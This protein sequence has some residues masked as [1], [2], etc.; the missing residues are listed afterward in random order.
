MKYTKLILG[1]FLVSVMLSA[2]LGFSQEVTNPDEVMSVTLLSPNSNAARNQ[3]ANLMQNELPKA[4]IGVAE[5]TNAGWDVVGPRTFAYPVSDTNVG[6][7]TYAD[8]GYDMVFIGLSGSLAYDPTGSYSTETLAPA[9]LNFAYYENTDLDELIVEYRTDLNATSRSETAKDIQA[10]LYED[11]PYI[12]IVN[13]A[14]LWASDSDMALTETELLFLGT[15]N[16]GDQWKGIS[17]PTDKDLVYAHSYE[18]TEFVPF[19]QQSYIAAAYMNTI[20]TGLY[21]RDDSDV[22][23]DY[24]PVLANSAPVWNTDYTVA[25]VSLNPAAKFSN[26]NSVTANDVVNTYRMHLTPAV[27]STLYGDIAPFMDK[28][29]GNESIVALDN[30]T[31]QFH[32]EDPYF[33]AQ[34]VMSIGVMDASVIGDYSSVSLNSTDFNA[35]AT[36]YG[37]GAGPFQYSDIDSANGNVKVTKVANYWN[38][39]VASDSVSFVKKTKTAVLSELASG[40]VHIADAQ[41]GLEKGEVEDLAGVSFAIVADFGTQFLTVN[42]K[43]PV[44]GTGVETPV[45]QADPTKAAEA[46]RNVR[47]AISHL[48][49][50]QTIIDDLLQGKGTAGTSLWPDVAAGYDSSLAVYEYSVDKAMEYLELAGYEIT[51]STDTTTSSQAANATS[52]AAETTSEA[53]FVP[54]EG[55]IPMAF[56][57]FFSSLMLI[58]RRN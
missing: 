23:Y 20:F 28:S 43:H 41:F 54:F 48:I 38:G 40:D 25:N 18:L 27:A 15:L 34:G 13:T 37:V 55:F 1:A 2:P 22:N 56:M 57:A 24:M 45:G 33:L 8:G 5:H 26:G 21:E 4:G 30:H 7:P 32:F 19:V 46:A 17:H 3:W 39:A 11:Q 16:Y 50:R 31:V 53:G 58:R 29:L 9:G 6:I 12:P 14:A 10:V 51:Y 44:L 36:K 35:N 49:P 47:K 42:M 52:S